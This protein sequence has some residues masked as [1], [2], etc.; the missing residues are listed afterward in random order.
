MRKLIFLYIAFF[1]FSGLLAQSYSFQ[2]I[3]VEEGLSQSVVNCVVQDDEG[4]FW[5]GTMSGLT[6]YDGRNFR[7]FTKSEGL[8]ENWV[9]SALKDKNGNLWFGHWGGGVSFYN[10]KLE[11]LKDP[12]IS[13][14]V[15]CKSRHRAN[16][17]DA[18]VVLDYAVH[19]R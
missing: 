8:S 14:V 15:P 17:K 16:P 13:A 5:I 19:N 10:K 9:T 11:K 2:Q 7:V 1:S 6:R 18:F 3:G 12:E 4:V